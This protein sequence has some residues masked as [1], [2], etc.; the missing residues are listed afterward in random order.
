MA[1][2]SLRVDGNGMA[3][4]P[5]DASEGQ[6]SDAAETTNSRDPCPTVEELISGYREHQQFARGHHNMP[7]LAIR[8]ADYVASLGLQCAGRQ[9]SYHRASTSIVSGL[10]PPGNRSG[11]RSTGPTGGLPTALPGT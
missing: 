7:V 11:A 10:D 5:R 3:T 4:A 9:D 6:L 8:L 2:V 1:G